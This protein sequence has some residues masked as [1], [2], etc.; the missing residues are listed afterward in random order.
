MKEAMH[1][2]GSVIAVRRDGSRRQRRRV[3]T[4]CSICNGRVWFQPLR[5]T[6]PEGVLEPRLTWTLCK[7]C[8]RALIAEMRISPVRSPLRLRV[9]VGIVASERWPQAY[10]TRVRTYLADRRLIVFVAVGLI[11]T[12]LVHLTLLVAIAALH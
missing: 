6:E 1:K 10:T 11:F 8:Y 12:M 2:N 9:A 5:I 4:H 7:P 3:V